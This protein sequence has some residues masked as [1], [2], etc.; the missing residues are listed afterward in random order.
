M[1]IKAI[2]GV[3]GAGKTLLALEMCLTELG[4][5]DQSSPEAI[6]RQLPEAK[7]PF[8]VCGVEGLRTGVFTEIEN[9]MDWQDLPDGTLILVDEAWKWWGKHLAHIRNDERYLKLAEHRH[10]GFDFVLTFQNPSQLQDHVRGLVGEH[11]HVTRKFGTSTTVRYEWPCLQESPNSAAIKKQA[12]EN[13]WRHP[14]GLYNL[15]QSATQH[16]I[17]RK[18]PK[19]LLVIPGILLA[20]A[21]AVPFVVKQLASI[22]DDVVPGAR[23]AEGEHASGTQ[24]EPGKKKPMNRE[25]WIAR[26]A[27]RVA[28][29]PMSA[30][31]F[32]NIEPAARP[33][34]ACM[35]G[36]RVGC[37]CK[38]D[39]GTEWKVH[40]KTCRAMVNAGGMYDYYREPDTSRQRSMDPNPVPEPQ[41][42][43]VQPV[44]GTESTAQQASYGGFRQGGLSPMNGS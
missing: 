35:I 36:E 10:R 3:P 1:P 22:G 4:I 32:D 17:K 16:T 18:I 21:I 26:F 37:I 20:C 43:P 29:V 24:S 38:T 28:E 11:H 33:K 14:K 41:T 15:Y 7:R 31:A 2:S 13:V 12:I 5:K 39:Q 25:E 30:P 6:Q 27:P 9:P 8:A 34:I 44:K 23:A 40:A 19:K 42:Q